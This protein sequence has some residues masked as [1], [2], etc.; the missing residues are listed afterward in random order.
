L[1]SAVPAPARL[2]HGLR[3]GAFRALP[4]E[5]VTPVA[6]DGERFGVAGLADGRTRIFD[7][8][9]GTTRDVSTPSCALGP[10]AQ[11]A[12]PLRLVGG[13]IIGWQCQTGQLGGQLIW[14][15]NLRTG[16]RSIPAGIRAFWQ[17]EIDT[18]GADGATFTLISVGRHWLYLI[19][20]G[21]HYTQDALIG[22]ETPRV[23]AG[24]AADDPRQA[25]ALNRPH[26]TRPLC[27]DI[28]RPA[29]IIDAGISELPHEP[30]LFDRPFAIDPYNHRPQA[31]Q[32]CARTRARPPRAPVSHAQLGGQL[33]T[34]AQESTVY[35][36]TYSSTYTASRDVRS[37]VGAVS[38]TRNRVFIPG[39][40][41]VLRRPS[42]R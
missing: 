12:P 41:A 22:I 18:N 33:L 34:W 27:R 31:I 1:V 16:R 29:G 39:Y 25:L 37:G 3:L 15:Q 24:P 13:G 26:G 6:T 21:Y 2:S 40:V 9:R 7:T 32:A 11:L 10:A 23:I 8:S 5:V 28:K 42:A 35:A 19:R 36:R 30:L 4:A 20:T 14:T 17:L 38:H